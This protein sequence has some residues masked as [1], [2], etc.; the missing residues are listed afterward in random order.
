MTKQLPLHNSGVPHE[1]RRGFQQFWGKVMSGCTSF[2]SAG[3]L[4]VVHLLVMPGFISRNWRESSSLGS[5]GTGHGHFANL[6]YGLGTSR[7]SRINLFIKFVENFYS[8]PWGGVKDPLWKVIIRHVDARLYRCA[9]LPS[10][11]LLM[12]SF[13][14]YVSPACP[15]TSAKSGLPDAS[16]VSVRVL[17]PLRFRTLHPPSHHRISRWR[18]PVIPALPTGGPIFVLFSLLRLLSR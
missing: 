4:S 8:D 1:Q 15:R 2:G 10:P 12:W 13:V 9:P 11:N 5:C 16:S 14:S 17:K 3:S 6:R 18:K 7:Q